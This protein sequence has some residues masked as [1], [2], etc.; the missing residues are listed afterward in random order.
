[1]YTFL[2]VWY[3][4]EIAIPHRN[5]CIII[6]TRCPKMKTTA[7]WRIRWQQLILTNYRELLGYIPA[8]GSVANH[9][10]YNVFHISTH[11]K[12]DSSENIL[13]ISMCIE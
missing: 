4:L 13:C 9:N 2:K 10:R 3:N 5:N 1:M 12:L 11:R 8:T 7:K 6:D